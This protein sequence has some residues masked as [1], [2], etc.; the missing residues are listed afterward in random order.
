MVALS[1][2]PHSFFAVV[3]RQVSFFHV[4]S[5]RPNVSR[6]A[7]NYPGID[8]SKADPN[9]ALASSFF[10]S[11]CF[12]PLFCG[13]ENKTTKQEKAKI[14][15]T[16][17]KRE[18]KTRSKKDGANTHTDKGRAD[19]NPKKEGP[20]HN[21]GGDPDPKSQLLCSFLRPRI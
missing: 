4:Q 20:A 11:C 7:V 3:T 13:K 5:L 21:P 19:P 17:K 10:G 14:E 15:E 9:F 6:P 2:A 18:E 12:A 1:A 16:M 8:V